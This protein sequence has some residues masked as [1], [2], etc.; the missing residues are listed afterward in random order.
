MTPVY[1]FR[2][3]HGALDSNYTLP[4]NNHYLISLENFASNN[5]FL[6]KHYHYY[7]LRKVHKRNN[8][9]SFEKLFSIFSGNFDIEFV[10]LVLCTLCLREVFKNC[11]SFLL[12]MALEF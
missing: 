12:S 4:K 11:E 5:L 8:L 9:F 10:Y 7:L 1:K 2:F 3:E 6:D